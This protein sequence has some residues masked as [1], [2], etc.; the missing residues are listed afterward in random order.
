MAHESNATQSDRKVIAR[1]ASGEI[2][3]SWEPAAVLPPLIAFLLLQELAHRDL[4]E[5]Y[6]GESSFV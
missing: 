3:L 2:I 4:D 1:S 5:R 6:P